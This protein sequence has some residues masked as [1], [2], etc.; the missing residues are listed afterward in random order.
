MQRIVDHPTEARKRREIG[1]GAE[2]KPAYS[3]ARNS[4]SRSFACAAASLA[5]GTR[6]PE[7]ET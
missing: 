6:G 5:I 4:A 7:Q 3:A 1:A 2:M